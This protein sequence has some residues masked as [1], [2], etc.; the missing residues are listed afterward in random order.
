MQAKLAAGLAFLSCR[1][2]ISTSQQR[3]LILLTVVI[4]RMRRGAISCKSR[5]IVI[6][7]A[8]NREIFLVRVK[9]LD[10]GLIFAKIAWTFLTE[11]YS[12]STRTHTHILSLFVSY[13]LP[14]P[15]S[16]RPRQHTA[17]YH[18]PRTRKDAVYLLRASSVSQTTCDS[19][20]IS[21]R[22][23]P[24]YRHRAKQ[25]FRG[26]VSLKFN[27]VPPTSSYASR[28]DTGR[29]PSRYARSAPL[30]AIRTRWNLPASTSRIDEERFAHRR[31][32]RREAAADRPL[33]SCSSRDR[34][35]A[36][37]ECAFLLARPPLSLDFLTAKNR[38]H[39][40]RRT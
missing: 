24:L 1:M 23:S 14:S 25:P 20:K 35:F 21:S 22:S 32:P 16:L 26:A 13:L 31:F 7:I 2:L 30:R 9:V 12:P 10:R 28:P 18:D 34:V 4:G 15:V 19:C 36:R 39:R 3:R 17:I 5:K 37:V 6:P 38:L 11:T 27:N 33:A 40:R 29:F 8:R